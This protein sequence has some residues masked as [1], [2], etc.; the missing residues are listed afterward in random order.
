MRIITRQS[1]ANE[2]AEQWRQQYPCNAAADKMAIWEQLKLLG[3]TPK[4]NDVDRAIG[5]KSW[6][7]VPTCTSCG[8]KRATVVAEFSDREDYDGY[9]SI[10][11]LKCLR[12]ALAKAS[13]KGEG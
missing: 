12:S 7:S 6:T 9:T 13:G 11:C 5:N 2:A 8:N 4:P 1:L 10:V 3:P